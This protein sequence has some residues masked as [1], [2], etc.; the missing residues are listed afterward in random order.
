MNR[1]LSIYIN[2]AV[3]DISVPEAMLTEAEAF[4]A[5]MDADMDQGYQMS[6]TWVEHPN[7]EQRCQIVADRILS[8][9]SNGKQEVGTLMAAY[10]L[11][12]A[13]HVRAVYC[14]SE[15]DMT[16]HELVTIDQIN[17]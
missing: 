8:A 4:F 13:P 12:R 15:G 5:R 17:A 10:I 9:L 14:N 3:R 16:G 7:L 11:K 6:R 2:N 1:Q